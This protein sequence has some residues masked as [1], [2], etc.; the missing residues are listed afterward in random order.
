MLRGKKA[1]EVKKR[2]NALLYGDMGTGKTTFALSLPNV[3]V[4]DA[5]GGATNNKYLKLIDKDGEDNGN[6]QET[7]E[8]DLVMAIVKDLLTLE[9]PY[10]TLVVDSITKIYD[11]LLEKAELEMARRPKKEGKFA[12]YQYAYKEMKKLLRLI[13]KLDMNVVIT[14]H[15]KDKWD[16]FKVIDT[17]FDG[18]KK[19]GY[20]L[21]LVL[22]TEKRGRDDFVGVVIKS[23]LDGFVPFDSFPLSY[24][25]LK[26]RSDLDISYASLV[27]KSTPVNLISSEQLKE[28]KRLIKLLNIEEV[29]LNKWF[30]K[31]KVSSLDHFDELT[32]KK[33]IEFLNSKIKGEEN[34]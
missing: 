28:L 5:E 13:K 30:T 31:E 25:E 6:Y 2:F 4:I 24:A 1:K 26:A 20:E 15:L 29:I 11:N 10:K 19:L 8:F 14:A 33:Y 17:T 7:E 16:D 32:G 34:V 21:D 9:H 3:Y 18:Y 23:R 22:R 27:E 12:H